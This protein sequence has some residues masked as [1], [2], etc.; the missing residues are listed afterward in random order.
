M[1]GEWLGD[2]GIQGDNFYPQSSEPNYPSQPSLAVIIPSLDE[3]NTI[4]RVVSKLSIVAPRASIT[5]VDGVSSDDSREM[6]RRAGAKVLT[7]PKKGY[8]RAIRTGIQSVEA[9]FYAMVDADDTYDLS[10]MPRMIELAASGRLVIGQRYGKGPGHGM[11]VSHSFGNRVLSIVHRILFGQRVNDT[12]SGMKVFPA[13]IA[14]MLREDG[15]TLSS[16]ILVVA[17][18][19]HLE[20]TEVPV[21]YSVRHRN[22]RSKFSFWKDGIPVLIFMIFSRFKRKSDST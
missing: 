6:A 3:A 4:L 13:R 9:D 2:F 10:V 7:E 21:R 5:V 1:I 12:Q 20:V 18:K 15:M 8:G 17:T 16:E 14:R 22:S 11:S 19:L